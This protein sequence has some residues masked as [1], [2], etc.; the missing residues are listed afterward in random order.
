[1][2]ERIKSLVRTQ[3]VFV[4]DLEVVFEALRR[5]ASGAANLSDYLILAGAHSEGATA[6]LTFDKKLAL[7]PDVELA[8]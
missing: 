6:L 3:G 2:R 8:R 1:V 7:E 5:D 4:P